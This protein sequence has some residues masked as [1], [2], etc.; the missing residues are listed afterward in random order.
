[1]KLLLKSRRL[2][3]A[4]IVTSVIFLVGVC[5]GSRTVVLFSAHDPRA[6]VPLANLV[7]S[8]I[9]S[10]LIMVAVPSLDDYE[11][12]SKRFL[13]WRIW[14]VLVVILIGYGLTRV[15][16]GDL[17][18]IPFSNEANRNLLG[19]LGAALLVSTFSPRMGLLVPTLQAIVAVAFGRREQFIFLTWPTFPATNSS[20]LALSVILFSLGSLCFV[21]V[22]HRLLRNQQLTLL[23]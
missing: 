23:Q 1:M 18:G 22:E 12:Q 6:A 10:A 17:L 13:N 3:F 20:A 7:P 15:I 9:V 4:L 2:P 8:L 14:A 5:V 21:L 11:R 16:V 19:F